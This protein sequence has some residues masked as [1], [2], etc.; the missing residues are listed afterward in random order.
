MGMDDNLARIALVAAILAV[1]G[2]TKSGRN[3]VLLFSKVCIVGA[4]GYYGIYLITG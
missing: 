4:L 3:G 1:F 2:L